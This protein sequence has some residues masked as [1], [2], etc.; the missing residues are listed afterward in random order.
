MPEIRI[1]TGPRFDASS[2][3]SPSSPSYRGVRDYRAV[4]SSLEPRLA[5]GYLGDAPQATFGKGQ[6]TEMA[7][8]GLLP[9]QAPSSLKVPGPASYHKTT[10]G[11]PP[12]PG[13]SSMGNQ[14]DSRRPTSHRTRVGSAARDA[15]MRQFVSR[16]HERELLGRTGPGPGSYLPP[17]TAVSLV[18]LPFSAPNLVGKVKADPY[19]A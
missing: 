5:S 3:S 12:P 19:Q 11:A 16:E 13:T 6:R 2:P 10:E 1:G 14:T 18:A 15:G 17:S 4:E 8:P 7:T 9:G